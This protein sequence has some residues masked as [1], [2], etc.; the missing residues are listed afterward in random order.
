MPSRRPRGADAGSLPDRV[1]RP[2]HGRRLAQLLRDA[3]LVEIR[4]SYTLIMRDQP[5]AFAEVIR[6]LVR[7]I[8]RASAAA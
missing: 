3:R 7:E 8:Q 6:R 1:Q 2:E 5:E 4:D